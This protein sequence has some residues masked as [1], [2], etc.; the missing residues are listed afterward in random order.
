MM[1]DFDEIVD[2]FERIF[3]RDQDCFIYLQNKTWTMMKFG[4]FLS[5]LESF[6]GRINGEL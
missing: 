3:M 4:L 1:N 6:K 5:R 2:F